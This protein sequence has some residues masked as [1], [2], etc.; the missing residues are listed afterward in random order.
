MHVKFLCGCSL[1]LASWATVTLVFGR[2][3]LSCG[4]SQKHWLRR[5]GGALGLPLLV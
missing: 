5:R 1:V 3:R 4:C 2:G